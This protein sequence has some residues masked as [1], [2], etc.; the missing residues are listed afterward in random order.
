MNPTDSSAGIKL[1][2]DLQ[3]RSYRVVV[4]QDKGAV[5]VYLG[6]REASIAQDVTATATTFG[7]ALEMAEFLRRR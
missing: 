5:T 6:K 3:R 1:S 4:Q 7:R 2:L